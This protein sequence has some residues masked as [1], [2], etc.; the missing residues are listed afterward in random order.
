MI[1]E[2]L[3]FGRIEVPEEAVVT[4]AEGMLGFPAR[5]RFCLFPYGPGS[6]LCWMQSIED[7]GLA[8]LVVEPHQLF[9][10]YEVELSD[11]HAAALE[12]E[13]PEDAALLALLTI[14][15]DARAVTANLAGPI[16]I[17]L[18]SRKA[19]Q[20]VLDDERYSTKHLLA[21]IGEAVR[22]GRI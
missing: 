20:V 11:A 13:R 17:N 16:V 22:E 14:S 12:L 5:R 21:S 6:A 7:Q 19:R 15:H 4:L 18:R 1:V 10:D 3:R 2:T 8:F 9:P